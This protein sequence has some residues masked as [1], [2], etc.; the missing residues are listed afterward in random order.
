MTTPRRLVTFEF[1]GLCLVAFLAVCNV[2]AF[3]NLFG[4]LASLGVP[5]SLRGL[6]GD[7]FKVLPELREKV[8][9]R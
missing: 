5:G 3:Y 6:V 1:V 9:A 2:T 8:R 7:L 4:Y